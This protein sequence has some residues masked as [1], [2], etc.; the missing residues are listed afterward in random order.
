MRKDK[1][2]RLLRRNGWRKGDSGGCYAYIKVPDEGSKDE[3]A[4]HEVAFSDTRR[5]SGTN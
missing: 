1:E 4:S 2:L 3:G 5:V